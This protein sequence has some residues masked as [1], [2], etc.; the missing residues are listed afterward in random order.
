M[1]VLL[2]VL[3]IP[4]GNHAAGKIKIRIMSMSRK[5]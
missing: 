3:V 1:L 4:G 2:I 5:P